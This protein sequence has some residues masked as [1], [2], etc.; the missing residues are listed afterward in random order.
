MHSQTLGLRVA[1]VL[2]GIMC[3]AQLLRLLIRPEVMVS[4]HSVPLWPSAL[5]IVVFGSLS[6]W[7]WS[8][9]HRATR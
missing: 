2:F 5:G 4:G 6:V 9:A 3:L 7:L 1:S 8:L